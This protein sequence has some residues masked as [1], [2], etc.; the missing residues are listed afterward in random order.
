[1]VRGDFAS[2][3]G[4]EPEVHIEGAQRTGYKGYSLVGTEDESSFRRTPGIAVVAPIPGLK[5]LIDSRNEPSSAPKWL[6]DRAAAIPSTNQIWFVGSTA[7]ATEKFVPPKSA[8]SN[9]TQ[10]VDRMQFLTA[11]ID[12]S[13]GLKVHIEGECADEKSA[14][15]IHDALRAVLGMLRLNTATD[16]T[17]LLRAYDAVKISWNQKTVTIDTDMPMRQVDA[18]LSL[19]KI[20]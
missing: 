16:A 11:Q 5:R 6:L 8:F 9:Y 7:G 15:G 20:K 2:E 1:M 4:K 13:R 19:A 12:V 10:F 14:R 17:D 18:L 3:L